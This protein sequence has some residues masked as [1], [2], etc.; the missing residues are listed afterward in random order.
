MSCSIS[1]EGTND[2]GSEE[3]EDWCSRVDWQYHLILEAVMTEFY[4]SFPQFQTCGAADGSCS[5]SRSTNSG[6]SSSWTNA[7]S[8]SANQS[9][10]SSTNNSQGPKRS[11]QDGGFGPA[12]DEQ[13]GTKK[14]RISWT[15]PRDPSDR[16]RYACPFFKHDL[17]K[18]SQR[19]SCRGPGFKLI[20]HVKYAQS[21]EISIPP[22]TDFVANKTLE[23]IFTVAT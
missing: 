21:Y 14:P 2:S 10:I 8:S 5:Q 20:S 23:N 16:R 4:T 6:Q 3:S 18:H 19:C 15:P 7:F 11:K 13:D 9:S 1:T 22:G 12:D 17:R